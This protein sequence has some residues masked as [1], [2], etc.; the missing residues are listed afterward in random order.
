MKKSTLRRIIKEVIEQNLSRRKQFKIN[1]LL[2]DPS[3]IKQAAQKITNT[4]KRGFNAEEFTN[5]FFQK[6][7]DAEV[8]GKDKGR[9]KC[10]HPAGMGFC[11]LGICVGKGS[12]NSVS[13]TWNIP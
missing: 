11:L 7:E 9:C 2:N 3:S 12:G 8:S 5:N 1:V 13:L 6:V 4:G 10:T